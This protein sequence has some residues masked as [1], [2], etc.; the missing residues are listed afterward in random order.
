MLNE[1]GIAHTTT[2][3]T[4]GDY[5]WKW[6]HGIERELPCLLVRKRAG[7]MLFSQWF[8]IQS[9][10][11]SKEVFKYEIEWRMTQLNRGSCSLNIQV[12]CQGRWRR[13]SFGVRYRKWW[14]GRKSSLRL[15][16]RVNY[17]TSLRVRQTTVIEVR[18]RAGIRPQRRSRSDNQALMDKPLESLFG[19]G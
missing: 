13:G 19:G 3:L 15:T 16:F 12:T 17:F 11:W 9:V 2:T 5:R 10:F 18:V 4:T 6:R 14:T 7:K 1:A 8:Q